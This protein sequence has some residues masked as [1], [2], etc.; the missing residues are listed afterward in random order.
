MAFAV[1]NVGTDDTPCRLLAALFSSEIYCYH[2]ENPS[3]TDVTLI[4]DMEI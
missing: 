4:S 2:E 3:G 1:K